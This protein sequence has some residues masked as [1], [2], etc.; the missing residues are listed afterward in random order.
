MNATD[1]DV[2]SS[3]EAQQNQLLKEATDFMPSPEA[4]QEKASFKSAA[5]AKRAPSHMRT[6]K[7]KYQAKPKSKRGGDRGHNESSS[8]ESDDIQKVCPADVTIYRCLL[9]Y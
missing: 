2:S 8:S 9:I 3:D 1:S 4:E 5:K 7:T 6:G